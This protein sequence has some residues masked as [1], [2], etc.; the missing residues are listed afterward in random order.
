MSLRRRF[1]ALP[2]EAISITVMKMAQGEKH[3]ALAHGASV[4]LAMT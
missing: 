1:A 4:T 2:D 3:T